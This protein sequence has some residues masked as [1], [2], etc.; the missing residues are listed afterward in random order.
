MIE[1]SRILEEYEFW[2]AVLSR[3][4]ELELQDDGVMFN[5]VK[6]MCSV[7]KDALYGNNGF[8]RTQDQWTETLKTAQ[9]VYDVL[10][11]LPV[12]EMD[13]VFF[14]N[15]RVTLWATA[16]VA[17]LDPKEVVDGKEEPLE[18]IPEDDITDVTTEIV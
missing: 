13:A 3:L 7:Y 6:C 2:S 1:A 16:I 12:C 8:M 15:A 11:D 5:A 17:G 18:D 4:T 14:Y 9:D 10:K